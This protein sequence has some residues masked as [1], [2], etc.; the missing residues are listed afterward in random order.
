M[1]NKQLTKKQINEVC[2]VILATIPHL[3][4]TDNKYNSV[5]YSIGYYGRS[6]ND[7]VDL[8]QNGYSEYSSFE[9]ELRSRTGIM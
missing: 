4:D 7:L 6:I 3:S 9:E 5:G 8:I 2:E 1:K